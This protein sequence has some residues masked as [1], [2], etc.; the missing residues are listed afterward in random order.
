M[1]DCTIRAKPPVA[2]P[3]NLRT[4]FDR[5]SK[6]GSVIRAKYPTDFTLSLST[7][8]GLVRK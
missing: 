3:L 6:T 4:S 7:G 1:K 5:L 2:F 8:E